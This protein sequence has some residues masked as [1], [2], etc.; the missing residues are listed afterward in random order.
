MK[1][2]ILD[3]LTMNPGDNPWDP[4]SALGELEVYDR[5]PEEEVVA[6][7]GDAEIVITNKTPLRAPTLARLPRLRCIGVLATGYDIV[8]VARAGELG[9][10][11]INVVNYG[12][13]SVAQQA[14]ALLLELCRRPAL[15]DAAIREGRWTSSEDF[16][17]WLSPQVELAGLTMG[18]VGFGTI[19]SKVGRIARAF[20]MEVLAA[21][22]R[23]SGKELAAGLQ[24]PGFPVEC[25]DLDELFRRSDVVSLH[26]PLSEA[27]RAMVNERT[28]GLMKRSAFLINVGR[29]PLVDEAAVARALKE[30]RIAGFG[31]DVVSVEP[32]A[33]DNP[34]LG[35]PNSVLTPHIAWATLGARKNITRILADNLRA[36]MGGELKSV[37]NLAQLR[38]A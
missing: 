9:V 8:D 18:V 30:G 13:Y 34:L 32:I 5:T 20:G 10:P 28:L 37:V 15:H 1:I 33:A 19:G 38:K 25:V 24:D 36:W 22:A 35:A 4:I 2:V 3:A 29:G 6:R 14:M 11:V 16:C 27:S 17:F 21:S 12:P 23:K 7:A 26:C 31:A